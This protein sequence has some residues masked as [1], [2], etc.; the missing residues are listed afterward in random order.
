MK[1]KNN[2]LILIL[3]IIAIIAV[4]FAVITFFFFG[5]LGSRISGYATT[6]STGEVNL[7][8]E[9]LAV[10]NFTTNV[11]NYGSGRVNS[12][13][14]HAA[15]TTFATGNVTGGNWTLQTA[16]GLRLQNLGNVNVSLNLSSSKA[17]ATFIGGTTPVFKWNV[18]NLEA[19]S[20]LNSTGTGETGL[21]LYAF[22][23]VNT[24]TTNFCPRLNYLDTA[25]TIRIDFNITVPADSQTGALTTTITATAD[26][27]LL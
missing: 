7:T 14:S 9:T 16:G 4:F 13:S 1:S 15:L 10:I 17:A 2:N 5:G 23:D 26:T 18:T 21:N 24:T 11:I 25:D 8:V 19:S 20:C 27:T 12:G 22:F 3:T 6:T